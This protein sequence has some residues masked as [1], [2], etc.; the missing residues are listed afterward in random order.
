MTR[1]HEPH[2][3]TTGFTY[4]T[5]NFLSNLPINLIEGHGLD[6]EETTSQETREVKQAHTS[7][8]IDGFLLGR[9]QSSSSTLL[10][11]VSTAETC[12]A[13]N[14]LTS[15]GNKKLKAKTVKQR[16]PAKS[17]KGTVNNAEAKPFS[18]DPNKLSTTPFHALLTTTPTSTTAKKRTMDALTREFGILNNENL[19][20]EPKTPQ[21][22]RRLLM[23]ECVT[24]TPSSRAHQLATASSSLSTASPSRTILHY[25]S[26]KPTN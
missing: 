6:M 14:A 13:S 2:T 19:N 21:S 22:K 23:P 7:K 9:R 5:S 20:L 10:S 3:K 4:S 11:S 8:T 26:P 12:T 16:Q 25:F 15:I 1:K 18:L 17:T 24:T